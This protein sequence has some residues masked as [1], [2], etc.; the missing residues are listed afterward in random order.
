MTE[1]FRVLIA[2]PIHEDGRKL[3]R[4]NAALAVDVET[5]LDAEALIGRMPRYDALIVRSK[6][7]V[8]GFYINGGWGT[9]GWKATPGS[10]HAFADLVAR[11]EPNAIAAPFTLERFSTGALVAEHGA[12]AVGH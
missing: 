12:A 5:G 7:R 2:D 9:G 6:T 3:L 11:D 1:T 8:T 10:G 4:G